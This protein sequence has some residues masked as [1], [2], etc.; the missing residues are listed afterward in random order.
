[1]QIWIH[2]KK[3]NKIFDIHIEMKFIAVKFLIDG[4]AVADM[5][6]ASW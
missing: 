5:E 4:R 3:Q 2:L 1:M 6:N